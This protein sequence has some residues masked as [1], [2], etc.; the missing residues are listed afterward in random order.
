MSAEQQNHEECKLFRQ[1]SKFVEQDGLLF[2]ETC[3]GLRLVV[4]R[5]QQDEILKECHDS[6][7]A[8]HRGKI[9]TNPKS[10]DPYMQNC[11]SCNRR[12]T[13]GKSRATFISCQKQ[14]DLFR[15]W[16]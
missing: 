1:Q 15:D 9:A 3:L 5:I 16:V 8:S 4:P 7:Y 6:V 2:R 12:T 13:Q 14:S 10:V 11:V